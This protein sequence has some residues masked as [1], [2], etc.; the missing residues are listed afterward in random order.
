MISQETED[1]ISLPMFTIAC[2]HAV[3]VNKELETTDVPIRGPCLI[4]GYIVPALVLR[5][6]RK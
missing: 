4:M 5:H 1:L 3:A 2:N 6:R